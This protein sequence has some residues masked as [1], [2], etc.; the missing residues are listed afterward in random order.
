MKATGAS[1]GHIN[2][3]MGPE[4]PQSNPRYRSV[5][6]GLGSL[7]VEFAPGREQPPN[8]QAQR[9]P[10]SLLVLL[11]ASRNLA[12]PLMAALGFGAAGGTMGSDTRQPRPLGAGEA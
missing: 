6:G 12:F 5:P 1:G 2:T 7:R 3:P 11:G 4:E 8:T 9:N 10:L